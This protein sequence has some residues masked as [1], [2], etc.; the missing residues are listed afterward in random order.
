MKSNSP[1]KQNG[2][3]INKFSIYF[4][5][6]VVYSLFILFLIVFFTAFSSVYINFKNINYVNITLIGIY[7]ILTGGFI[8]GIR[9]R[10]S[11]KKMFYAILISGFILR[12]A[13]ALVTKSTPI[14]DFKTIYDSA[15]N[16][17]AGDNSSFVGLGYFARF[18]HMTPYVL[19]FSLIIKFFGSNALFVMKM[20]NVIFS[21]GAI[22]LVY[23]IC[24]KIF[25]DY[26]K[27]LLGT[28]FISI[29]PSAILYVPVYCSE[30]IAIPFYL[31]S[32]YLFILVVEKKNNCLL[33]ALSGIL[34]CIGH[35][36]RMVAYIILIAYVM[37]IF[38]YN[39]EKI[40]IKLRNILLI[41]IPFI[42]LFVVFSNSLI[43][44]NITDRNIWDGSEPNITS[45]VRGSNLESGGSWNPD[46][47]K[48]IEDL[49]HTT[50]K[51][52][53]AE[54][55]K[56]RI[57]E[58]YTTTPPLELGKFFVRKI[59]TQWAFGDN[60]GAYWSQLGIDENNVI[61][62]ISGKG[63]LWYQL[64]YS[65]LLLF[66]MK[67]LFNK[68]EHIDN[69]IINLFYIILCGFGA[70]LLILENQCRYAFIINYIFA[71]LPVTAFK[72]SNE[73]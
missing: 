31:A 54:A 68:T 67:G 21:T 10:I 46:D 33:L 28:F 49:L 58:R 19:L 18:P 13:W 57:I 43:K 56:E 29:L 61:F 53:V 45:A 26:K 5:N 6:F 22:I 37:Y 4:T 30:N 15:T 40:I 41:L 20:I 60:A 24:N 11:K 59:A 70:M 73:K 17:L 39:K 42:L 69:K 51:E 52:S 3:T 16:L 62:D 23:L 48:F 12:L 14:S 50:D 27:V 55:C 63:F 2:P 71:I 66:I 32:I 9:K 44:M 38:I 35:L 34:L 47:A 65:I 64:V 8:Y 72:S 36:F 25:K 7:L 1:N